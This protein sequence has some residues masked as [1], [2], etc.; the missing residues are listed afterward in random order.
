IADQHGATSIANVTIAVIGKND[1]PTAVSDSTSVT[2]D[3]TITVTNT[4]LLAN[5]TDIDR[6]YALTVIGHATTSSRGVVVSDTTN[7]GFVY[8]ANSDNGFDTLAFGDASTDT[9]TYTIA[10][11]HGATSI[12]NVTI[13]VIG[14]NDAPTAVSDSTSVTE[15][16]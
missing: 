4:S 12:A 6:A 1:A 13:A 3:N 5:D 11:Q 15:D 16:N 2:E 8:D 10:D 9:V 14:K 7:H